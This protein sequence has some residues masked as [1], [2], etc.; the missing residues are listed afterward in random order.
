MSQIETLKRLEA[1]LESFLDRA[2]YVKS[3]RI[4]VLGLQDA[5]VYL[6]AL[7]ARHGL[8]AVLPETVGI[9]VTAGREEF[10]RHL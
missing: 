10:R 5:T 7:T 4:D 6:T 3:E 2:V 9:V 8:A 1:T